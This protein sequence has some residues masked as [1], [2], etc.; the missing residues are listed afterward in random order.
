MLDLNRIPHLAVRH[1][2]HK[3]HLFCIVYQWFPYQPFI[4]WIIIKNL[5]F[6]VDFEVLHLF[7]VDNSVA[8]SSV[9]AIISEVSV[10]DNGSILHQS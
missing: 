1:A 2:N 9:W 8:R 10:A 6:E 7:Y 5:K 3:I 4:K